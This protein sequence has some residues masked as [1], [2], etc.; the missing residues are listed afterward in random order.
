[1]SFQFVDNAAIDRRS[2]K[3]IR[4]HVMKGIN[5][6]RTITRPSK[7]VLGKQTASPITSNSTSS[8]SNRV[9]ISTAKQ[10]HEPS[11]T[12][13]VFPL[14]HRFSSMRLPIE[15]GPYARRRLTQFF[16]LVD[17]SLYPPEFCYRQGHVTSLWFQYIS[18]DAAFLHCTVAMCASFIDLFLGKQEVIGRP[19]IPREALLH[20][21]QAFQ[22][23]NRKLAS[24]EALADNTMA[25]LVSLSLHEQLL[26]DY[27]TGH[28]H[29]AGLAKM[30]GLRGGLLHLPRE[31][32]QKIC[33]C[34]IDVALHN[35]TP[36]LLQ[37]PGVSGDQVYAVFGSSRKHSRLAE[38]RPD[39]GLECIAADVSTVADF[40]NAETKQRKLDP[41]AY[42]DLVIDLG[43]RLLESRPPCGSQGQDTL[44][45][46]LHLALTAFMTTQT[47]GELGIRGWESLLHVL[48]QY[49]WV[50]VLHD[51]AARR[52]WH[53]LRAF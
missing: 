22:L 43:Y 44:Q 26:T 3:L 48:S 12:G 5:K 30:V 2:R 45:A 7:K 37:Y 15:P 1:M 28:I 40:L 42:Q 36:P 8:S 19:D 51:V 16:H 24:Q 6:G 34:D 53:L 31:L 50:S 10:A 9:G 35:G 33:R 46:A 21:A 41:A 32:A 38:L 4:S 29:L 23:T 13:I 20:I 14:G 25:S 39:S 27:A 18:T 49:P 47:A 11:I 17:D 52:L